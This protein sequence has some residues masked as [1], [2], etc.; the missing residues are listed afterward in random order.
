MFFNAM[1]RKNWNPDEKDMHTVVPIHNA[2]NE[3]AWKKI[4]EWESLHQ[5]YECSF[6]IERNKQ[7]I[8][9]ILISVASDCNQ[10]KLLK[11]QGRPK[12]VTP[13]AWIRSL[14]G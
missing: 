6:L 1:K 8:H 2:V 7:F 10:P 3:Q 4:L 5:R 11:F 12:D 14:F 13:K 9:L